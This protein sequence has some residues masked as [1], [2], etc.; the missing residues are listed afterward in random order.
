M[1]T[2]FQVGPLYI[3]FY[4][5]ILMLG[6]L[7]GAWL[8][9]REAKRKGYDPEI[10]MDALVWVLIGGIIGA[11]LWHVFTPP[12]SMTSQGI[13][14]SWYLMHPLDI[15]ATWR[16]GLGLP[17][18]VLGGSIALLLFCRR[19]KHDFLALADIAAPG[20]ALGQAIGRWGNFINQEVYGAPSNLPWAVKIDPAYRLP[21]YENIATY[22][23]LFLYESLW[24][25]L[26]L[27]V[28]LWL[29]RKYANWLK[30]GDLLL[31]YLIIYPLGRFLLEFLRLDP[32]RVGPV[33]I[34]QLLMGLVALA[35]A[36]GLAWRHLHK[37][38]AEPETDE[39]A[40]EEPEP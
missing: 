1:P 38:P 11:R 40:A 20:L 9:S 31:V 8:A 14:A 27:G 35:A 12:A 6:A 10:V 30:K 24:N 3:H 25:L 29:S 26:N 23:P 2:G 34:N 13:T 7:A 18:A 22:H 33:N 16:G 5:I 32:S 28:L 39:P 37:P 19:N 36:G 4:G 17:G 21:G 15:L